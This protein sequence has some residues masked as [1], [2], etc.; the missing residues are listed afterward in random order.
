[1]KKED[2][3]EEFKNPTVLLVKDEA[4]ILHALK[5]RYR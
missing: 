1:M 2:T 5:R 3:M 4:E